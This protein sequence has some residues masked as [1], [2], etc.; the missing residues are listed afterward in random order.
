MTIQ[1]DNLTPFE[2]F[3]LQQYGNILRDGKPVTIEEFENRAAEIERDED[4]VNTYY[5]LQL[6]NQ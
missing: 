1:N 4:R 6:L 5:E 2:R 3:Q